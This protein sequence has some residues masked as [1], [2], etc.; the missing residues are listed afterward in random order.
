MKFLAYLMGTVSS[1]SRI[2]FLEDYDFSLSFSLKKQTKPKPKQKKTPKINT[3]R[4]LSM[5]W[6]IHI[7]QCIPSN[8]QLLKAGHCFSQLI[9]MHRYVK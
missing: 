8:L 9:E 6:A 7:L 4:H 3:F 5:L 2:S 1:P